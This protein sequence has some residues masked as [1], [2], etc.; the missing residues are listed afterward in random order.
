MEAVLLKHLHITCVALSYSLFFV[1]GVWMLRGTLA[2]RGRWVRIAPHMVDSVL[3]VSAVTLA[4]KMGISPMSAPW[5]IAKIIA[6][7]LYIALGAVA[8]RRGRTQRIRLAAWLSAQAV[9]FY[10][11]SVAVT[12]DPAPWHVLGD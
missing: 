2:L 7:L 10:I 4:V 1:R 8:L 6:L 9:F 5:L 12:H 11:V 3:L